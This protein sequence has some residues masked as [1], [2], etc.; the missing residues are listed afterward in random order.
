MAHE[1]VENFPFSKIFIYIY[2]CVCV[3]VCVCV[4]ECEDSFFFFFLAL[5]LKKL[6]KR[7]LFLSFP[8]LA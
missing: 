3:C 6:V 4:C 7:K 2:M 1:N 5:V 8:Y